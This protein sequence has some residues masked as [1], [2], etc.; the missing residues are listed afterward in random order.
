M[1]GRDGDWVGFLSANFSFSFL[2]KGLDEAMVATGIKGAVSDPIQMGFVANDIRVAANKDFL[3]KNP[4]AK[5][6][7]ECMKVPLRDIA[8]QNER[9]FEGEDDQEDVERHARE[10]IKANQEFWNTCLDEARAAA[11]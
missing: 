10:W 7:F 2:N 11:Q 3:E 1:E 8:A 6:F 5:K 4:A 9:Y